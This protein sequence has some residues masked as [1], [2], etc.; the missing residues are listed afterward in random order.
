MKPVALVQHMV[1]NSSRQ[2]NI[3]YDCFGGSGTTL[4]A[5]GNEGRICR[6]IELSPN[7]GAVILERFHTAFPDEEIR[8]IE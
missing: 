7:Y 2:G 8:L 4:L 3:V 1:R 5:C 6:I